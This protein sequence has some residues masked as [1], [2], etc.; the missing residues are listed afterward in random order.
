ML[1]SDAVGN[2]RTTFS[3][4]SHD[5]VTAGDI[6]WTATIDDDDPDADLAVS[7]TRVVD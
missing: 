7:G 2:G 6:S 5:P 4:S 1:V 3:F